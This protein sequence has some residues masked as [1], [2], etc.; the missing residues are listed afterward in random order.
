VECRD[1]SV[2]ISEKRHCSETICLILSGISSFMKKIA[3][4]LTSTQLT[5]KKNGE[6]CYALKSRMMKSMMTQSVEFSPGEEFEEK[7]LDGRKVKSI[8][9]FHGNQI[10]HVQNVNS[11]KPLRIQRTFMQDEM[12]EISTYGD[13][14][15]TSWFAFTK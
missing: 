15:S 11:E 2:L 7:T 14:T 10:V 4:T 9:T 5:K 1:K 3:S 13:I 12:V 8:I 6:N